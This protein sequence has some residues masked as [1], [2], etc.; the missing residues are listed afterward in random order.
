M[1]QM[2]PVNTPPTEAVATPSRDPSSWPLQADDPQ[3]TVPSPQETTSNPST[4]GKGPVRKRTE[5]APGDDAATPLW[6]PKSIG[7]MLNIIIGLRGKYDIGGGGFK[8]QMW[9]VVKDQMEQKGHVRNVQQ[10][11]N[12]VGWLKTR[13]CERQKLLEKSGFGIDPTTKRVT[14]SED[15]WTQLGKVSNKIL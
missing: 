9:R 11:K 8:N 14:A 7:D 6:I 3:S 13:W 5:K 15:C 1:P 10:L 12:K 2:T 4:A